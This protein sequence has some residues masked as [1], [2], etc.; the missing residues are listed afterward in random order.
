MPDSAWERKIESLERTSTCAVSKN[1]ERAASAACC[2]TRNRGFQ[3][4]HF[5]MFF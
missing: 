5:A 3:F 1:G 4:L 2:K